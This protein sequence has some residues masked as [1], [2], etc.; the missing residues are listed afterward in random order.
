MQVFN[1]DM[2]PLLILVACICIA[3]PNMIPTVANY[4]T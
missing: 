2:A 4:G 1:E 3:S